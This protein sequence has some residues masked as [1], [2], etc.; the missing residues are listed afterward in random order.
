[1]GID[2]GSNSSIFFAHRIGSP[3]PLKQIALQLM[4]ESSSSHDKSVESTSRN[5]YHVKSMSSFRALYEGMQ[6]DWYDTELRR[7]LAPFCCEVALACRAFDQSSWSTV[8]DAFRIQSEDHAEDADGRSACLV[9]AKFGRPPHPH[10]VP[11]FVHSRFSAE[12]PRLWTESRLWDE[13]NRI[14]AKIHRL[15]D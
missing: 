13:I 6:I 7:T 11:F 9:M 2:D 5:R 14:R 1:M 4:K 12:N 15:D 10:H 8:D 3:S